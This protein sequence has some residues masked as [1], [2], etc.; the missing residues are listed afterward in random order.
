MD[1]QK[2]LFFGFEV[3]APWPEDL[4]DA[5]TLKSKHRHLTIAFLGNTSYSK[6]RSLIPKI[7]KPPFRVG[8]IGVADSIL[9]LPRRHPCVVTWHI[10]SFGSDPL[11]DFQKNLSDFLEENGYEMDQRKFLKHITLGRSPFKEEEWKKGFQPLPVYFHHFHLFESFKGL[12]YEPIWS[13]DLLPPF[14]EIEH[15]AD[16]AFRIYGESLQEIF[17]N[18]QI[19]LAFKCPAILPHLDPEYQIHTIEDGII[20][21]NG[22]ITEADKDIGTPFK[23]VSFHGDVHLVKGVKCWEMI[24]DV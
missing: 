2:R 5:R 12:C 18:A 20:R 14:E 3:H 1:D 8:P 9:C 13:H 22:I 11:N 15:V 7:P 24:V 19:A 10:D 23:A 21:L 16:I 17:W 4:P 6:I